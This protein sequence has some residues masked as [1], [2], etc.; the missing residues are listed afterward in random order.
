[1]VIM[2]VLL[3]GVRGSFAAWC[4]W[5][6]CSMVAGGQ[7]KEPGQQVFLVPQS[8]LSVAVCRQMKQLATE[9]LCRQMKQLATEW[10]CVVR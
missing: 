10:L 9:W 4:S 7:S 5:F 6:F 3:H 8:A 1:M 2:V